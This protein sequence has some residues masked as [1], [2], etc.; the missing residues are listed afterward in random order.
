[1]SNKYKCIKKVHFMEIPS[2][3]YID[4]DTVTFK[5]GLHV[6]LTNPQGEKHKLYIPER[7]HLN[8]KDLKQSKLN[9]DTYDITA[10][11]VYQYY[12]RL[13]I[14]TCQWKILWK[15]L[16]YSNSLIMTIKKFL[17]ILELT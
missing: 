17:E 16:R 5:N 15:L 7:F 9:Y 6:Y 10:M 11:Y 14:T 8:V 12:Q 2:I 13:S 3:K 1:M 4:D